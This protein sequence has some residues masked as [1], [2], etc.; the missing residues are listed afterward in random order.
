MSLQ[1][2]PVASSHKHALGELSE[3]VEW[4]EDMGCGPAKLSPIGTP[5]KCNQPFMGDPLKDIAR[6]C[7][8]NKCDIDPDCSCPLCTEY[9]P[10]DDEHDITEQINQHS[11]HLGIV[12]F[13]PLF[14]G[15]VDDTTVVEK[16]FDLLEDET[17]M[18]SA[19]GVR[20]LSA[21]D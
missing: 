15:L 11:V 21:R 8:T 3:L 20:S 9:T 10:I 4:R 1:A 7:R 2:Q 5:A 16:L 13:F 6:C 12:N 19:H 18:M 17:R 14:Y